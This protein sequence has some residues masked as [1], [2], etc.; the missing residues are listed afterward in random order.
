MAVQ[1]KTNQTLTL[2]IKRLGINGEGIAYYKRLIIFVTGALPNETVV[3]RISKATPRFAE[4][5]LVKII[6]KSP[7]RII[8]PCPVYEECGGCQ[9]QHLAYNKQLDFKKDLLRQALEKYKPDGYQ[10]F[11]L[12]DTLGME[13]PWHYRNKAQ[14]QLRKNKQ[15]NQVEAG[16]YRADSHQ[17]VPLKDCLVQEETTQKVINTVTNLLTKYDVPIYDERINAGILRTLMVRIGIETGEVQVVLVTK[18]KKIPKVNPLIREI[19]QRL[20]EVV[21]IMQNIQDKKTSVIMGDETIHLWG[22]E[23]INEKIDEVSFELSP[24]AFFQLN[25]QQTKVLYQEAVN[26][27]DL[28]TPKT[29]VD[30]YCGVGTIGLSLAKRAKE[31][32][33]MDIISQAIDDAKKNAEAMNLT[34]THYEV[35]TAESLLPKWLKEGFSPDAIVVDPPRTGLDDQLLKAIQASPSPQMVYISCNVSTLARDLVSLSKI[36]HVDYL[37]S[38]DMFPQTARCEVVVKLS[39]K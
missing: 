20:P 37:Q 31:V 26:A 19:T 36:Y 30:A 4:A 17:L 23:V 15:T 34:N 33:G 16:L 10:D 22:K 27:L 12:R 6:K 38:V 2:K 14:F 8:P 18:T 28:S 11:E 3:A 1:L 13:D 32:R 7:D 9:L 35:G 21:S 24:R 25:P 39:K 29:I 5:D